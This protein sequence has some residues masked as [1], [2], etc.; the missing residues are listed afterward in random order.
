MLQACYEHAVA[1]LQVKNVPAALHRR[2]RRL[3][4]QQGKTVGEVVL[5]AVD[6]ARARAEWIER[7]KGRERT[8]LARPAAEAVE[9][10]RDARERELAS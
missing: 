4:K 10:E 1:N 8:A 3:A 6:R 7:R 2:I 9:Q 5:D